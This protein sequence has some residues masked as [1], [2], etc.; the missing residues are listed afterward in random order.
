MDGMAAGTV[1]A[2]GTAM[3]APAVIIDASAPC[4]G[5]RDVDMRVR[6]YTAASP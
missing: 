5:A 3:I 2:A 6:V 4:D 1:N